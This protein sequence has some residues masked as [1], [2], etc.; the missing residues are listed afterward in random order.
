MAWTDW[1]IDEPGFKVVGAPAISSWQEGRLDVFLRSTESRLYHRVFENNMWQGVDW[2]EISD[3]HMIEVSPAAVSWGPNRIDLFAVWDKQLHHR[4]FQNGVWNPWTENLDG[5]TND[6]PTA[7]SWK[8]E[9]VDALVHTTDD[10]MSRR[11]WESGVLLG[12]TGWE[13][14]GGMSTHLLSAPA[15]AATG[16]HRIDCFGRGPSDHLIHAWYQDN[17]QQPWAEI[18]SLPFKDAPTVISATT[19]D[20]GRVDVF[21]R[22]TDDVLKHRIYYSALQPYQP[23]SE[24]VHIVAQGDTMLKIAQRYGLTLAQLEALNPQ[25]TNPDL[26]HPGDRIIV[27][28]HEALPGYGDWETGGGWQDLTPGQIASAP[29][30]VG[31]WNGNFITRVDCFAQD[32]NNRLMHKWWT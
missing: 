30:A 19:A 18:D 21:V 29:A 25:T 13:N 5:A 23:G 11:Y 24:I 1:T 32:A 28:H 12:W 10:F 17:Y 8:I 16:P 15:A 7:A 14:T 27:G 31:W 22:G 26:I 9:R 4:A 6:A 2:E 20:R 3:G